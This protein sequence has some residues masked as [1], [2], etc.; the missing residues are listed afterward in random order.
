MIL[1]IMQPY[2]FPYLGYFDLINY[3]DKWIVFD[4]VQY[5][6]GGWVN[7]NRILFPQKQYGYIT[8]PVKKHKLNIAIKDIEISK[9]FKWCN[10]ILAQLKHYKRKAPYFD[11]VYQLV[12]KSLEIE[13]YSLSRLNVKI[14]E[15]VCQFIEIPFSYDYFSE[16]NLELGAINEAE[17]WALQISKVLK[18]TEYVN[19]PGG[20]AIYNPLNFDTAGINL[21]IRQ[22]PE[23]EYICKG[24]D[25][26]PHLSIIDVLMWNKPADVKNYLDNKLA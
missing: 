26:L 7:R 8:I 5:M 18:A 21:T 11:D 25:F 6:K 1:G 15:K 2:F 23:F 16:M 20:I 9:N 19:A 13:E 22:L 17:D 12:E 24:Y 3:S 10:N 14:L 4:T